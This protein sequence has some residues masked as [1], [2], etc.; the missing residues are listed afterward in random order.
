MAL[1]EELGDIQVWLLRYWNLLITYSW[2]ADISHQHRVGRNFKGPLRYLEGELSRNL[3]AKVITFGTNARLEGGTYCQAKKHQ[4]R[5]TND[6]RN[7][8]EVD[9]T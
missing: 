9:R 8:R 6:Y 7:M 5:N 2:I 3:S 4:I 1:M